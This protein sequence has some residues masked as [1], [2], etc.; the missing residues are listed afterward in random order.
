LS[1]SLA[2]TKLEA[3]ADVCPCVAVTFEAVATGA[4]F[5]NGLAVNC[6]QPA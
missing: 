6:S 3:A 4:W 1:A 2:P 5:K